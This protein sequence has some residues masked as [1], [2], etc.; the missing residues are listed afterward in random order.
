MPSSSFLWPVYVKSVPV[1]GELGIVRAS[2][3]GRHLCW[4][5]KVPLESV[6]ATVELRW[7]NSRYFNPVPSLTATICTPMVSYFFTAESFPSYCPPMK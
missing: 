7:S 5:V 2:P 3:K 1:M 4:D 6:T